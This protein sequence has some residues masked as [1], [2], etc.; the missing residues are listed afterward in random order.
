MSTPTHSDPGEWKKK[1]T[2]LRWALNHTRQ[3]E[4]WLLHAN[5]AQQRCRW[6]LRANTRGIVVSFLQPGR[7][8][9]WLTAEAHRN[10]SVSRGGCLLLRQAHS[11][12]TAPCSEAHGVLNT[13][14]LAEQTSEGLAQKCDF[15]L[16]TSPHLEWEGF[17]SLSQ[18]K[19]I[20]WA[21]KAVK[22]SSV[23]CPM[24]CRS[25]WVSPDAVIGIDVWYMHRADRCCKSV[26][27]YKNLSGVESH[28]WRITLRQQ[29]LNDNLVPPLVIKTAPR[30][31]NKNFWGFQEQQLEQ[32]NRS[33]WKWSCLMWFHI[34]RERGWLSFFPKA[35]VAIRFKVW[36]ELGCLNFEWQTV[37]VEWNNMH[38]HFNLHGFAQ[39]SFLPAH[40]WRGRWSERVRP[41]FTGAENPVRLG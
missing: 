34:L 35:S 28:F 41:L 18:W 6:R 33:K 1:K 3:A 4:P 26:S 23:V 31:W 37:R 12:R 27:S 7:L 21:G 39:V 14:S 10:I 24:C 36:C 38:L 5:W 13:L 32:V 25:W 8:A 19:L 15:F 22:F 11:P 17:F 20:V 2:T 30:L 16:L 29:V 40:L 9:R